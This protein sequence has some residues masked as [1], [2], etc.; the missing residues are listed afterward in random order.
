MRGN[1]RRTL[2]RRKRTGQ[3]KAGEARDRHF[4]RSAVCQGHFSKSIMYQGLVYNKVISQRNISWT[5]VRIS[6][7]DI[8][9]G[10]TYIKVLHQGQACLKVMHFSW[11]LLKVRHISD[12]M[13]I[14]RLFLQ[15]ISIGQT[16]LMVRQFFSSCISEGHLSRSDMFQGKAYL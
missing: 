14:R 12:A 7:S 2:A 6:R 9:H 4:S 15:A 13:R 11:S 10:R 8:S 16:H 1:G 5:V 3:L